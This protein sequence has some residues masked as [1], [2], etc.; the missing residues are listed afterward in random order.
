[1]ITFTDLLKR[2]ESEHIAIHTPTAKQAK[3]LLKALDK[4][5]Y[6]WFLGDKLTTKTLY[7]EYKENTCYNFEPNNKIC[8]SPLRFYQNEGYAIIEFTEIDFAEI[9]D[10]KLYKGGK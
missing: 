8:Y 5:G 2:A 9:F 10:D 3:T 7:K 6:E 1:M 4:R